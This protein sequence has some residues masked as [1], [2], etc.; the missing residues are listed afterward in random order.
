M[1]IDYESVK[2]LSV[3]CKVV[4]RWVTTSCCFMSDKFNRV[5]K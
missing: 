5:T 3:S 4:Y 2:F 1:L